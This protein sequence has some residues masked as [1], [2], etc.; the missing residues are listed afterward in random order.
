MKV[1]DSLAKEMKEPGWNSWSRLQWV[2]WPR[3]RI[4]NPYP[5][6]GRF[7]HGSTPFWRTHRQDGARQLCE[8]G[9]FHRLPRHLTV[10]FT[11]H[12]R[13]VDKYLGCNYCTLHSFIFRSQ[14]KKEISSGEGRVSLWRVSPVVTPSE[15]FEL[16]GTL[17]RALMRGDSA[18]VFAST[19]RNCRKPS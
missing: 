18:F 4:Y 19:F 17:A 16:R 2:P 6:D 13:C 5:L 12:L 8:Q 14:V 9:L 3:C 7:C 11:S 15:A 10:C 1:C